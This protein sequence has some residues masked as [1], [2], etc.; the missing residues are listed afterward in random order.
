MTQL[1]L[2]KVCDCCG[3]QLKLLNRSWDA[4]HLC[5]RCNA[6]AL[7]ENAHADG[8]HADAADE[9]CHVCTATDPHAGLRDQAVNGDQGKVLT[10][11]DGRLGVNRPAPAE[12]AARVRVLSHRNYGVNTPLVGA[13]G[14][15]ILTDEARGY[16]KVKLDTRTA[17]LWFLLTDLEPETPVRAPRVRRSRRAAV[18]TEAAA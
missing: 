8:H 6:E 10:E 9:S 14:A 17:V 2:P 13:V 1:N 15:V 5:V 12:D 7:N 4:A 11:A 18:A 16:A 3:R